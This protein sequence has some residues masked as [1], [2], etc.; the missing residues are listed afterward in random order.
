MLGRAILQGN[1]NSLFLIALEGGGM[2]SLEQ[3][4]VFA[5]SLR[6]SQSTEADCDS[7]GVAE[8]PAQA[9]PFFGWKV[10]AATAVLAGS[11]RS[12]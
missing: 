7:I 2:I 10:A 1:R 5:K 9:A 6:S 8:A 4:P 11:V 12:K 3:T